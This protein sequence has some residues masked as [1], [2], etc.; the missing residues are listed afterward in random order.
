MRKS[1]KNGAG[2]SETIK[3]EGEGSIIISFWKPFVTI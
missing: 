2:I 1:R 3:K